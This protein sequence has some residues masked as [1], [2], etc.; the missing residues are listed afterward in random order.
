MP[1]VSYRKNVT[2]FA[3]FNNSMGEW[4]TPITAMPDYSP[5]ECIICLIT[6]RGDEADLNAYMIWTNINNDFI[7]SVCGGNIV[8]V[9]PNITIRLT[10]PLTN[11]I[12]L[13]MYS[14]G[15]TGISP[16]N[17]MS[18]EIVLHLEFVKYKRIPQ[19]V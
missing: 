10:S 4:M 19:Q 15:S 1:E 6:F 17:T 7:G 3:Y 18:G 8:S 5:D 13:K 2:S 16:V 14:P 11:V 12:Q 9:S